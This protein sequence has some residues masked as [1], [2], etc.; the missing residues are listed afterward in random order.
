MEG[1]PARGEVPF[2]PQAKRLFGLE[3]GGCPV[4]IMKNPGG[5]GI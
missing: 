3:P 5:R 1:T 4:G 2:I